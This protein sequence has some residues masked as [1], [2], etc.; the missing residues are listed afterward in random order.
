MYYVY[1]MTNTFNSTLYVGMT[2]D[3]RRRVTEHRTN[4]NPDSFTAKYHAHKLV[5]FEQTKSVYSAISREKQI[6]DWSRKKKLDLI[7]GTNPSFVD[8]YPTL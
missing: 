1:I 2:N 4:R 8:L 5:W 3:L 6:K 7:L